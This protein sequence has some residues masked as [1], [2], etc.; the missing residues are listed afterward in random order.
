M[1]PHSLS[2][3]R[4]NLTCRSSSTFRTCRGLRLPHLPLRQPA[5]CAT[6]K[7]CN[8]LARASDVGRGYLEPGVI[9]SSRA[10]YREFSKFA[11]TV[12]LEPVCRLSSGGL[13]GSR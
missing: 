4:R 2:A 12:T 8:R 9:V 11:I 13:E 10:T 7:F 1:F 3:T 5:V 6:L